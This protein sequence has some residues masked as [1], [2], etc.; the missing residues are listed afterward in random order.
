VQDT[1]MLKLTSEQRCSF[2]QLEIPAGTW[3]LEGTGG[4]VYCGSECM[5]RDDD[6]RGTLRRP[7]TRTPAEIAAAWVTD[8]HS[9][10]DANG[11]A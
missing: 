6:G 2:C 11:T 7:D 3:V 8:N 9:E 10:H 5:S 4:S 1:G